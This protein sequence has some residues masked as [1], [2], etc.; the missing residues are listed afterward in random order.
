MCYTFFRQFGIVVKGKLFCFVPIV[1]SGLR[2]I[3]FEAQHESI[4]RSR[5]SVRVGRKVTGSS[6]HDVK[7]SLTAN[8]IDFNLTRY[9]GGIFC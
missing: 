6:I 9:V 5:V 4:E 2:R 7:D 8:K 1:M 3:P